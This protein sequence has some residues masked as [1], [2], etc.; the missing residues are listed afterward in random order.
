MLAKAMD[1]IVQVFRSSVGFVGRM[2]YG[3]L[4]S[5]VLLLGALFGS[6]TRPISQRERDQ[7]NLYSSVSFESVAGH[8]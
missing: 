8:D 4:G 3:R 5:S 1:I 7:T 6:L 2:R